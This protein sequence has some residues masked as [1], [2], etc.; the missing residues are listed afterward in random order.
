MKV[1]GLLLFSLALAAVMACFAFYVNGLLPEGT[2]LPI[3]WNAA[4]EVDGSANALTALLLPPALAAGLALLFAIVPSIEPLQE[5]LAGSAHFHRIGWI[6][7]MALMLL[8]QLVIAAPVFGL[9]IGSS[10]IVIAAGFMLM[11]M[12]NALPKTRPGFFLGIRTPWTITDTD[13]WIATHRLGGK[14]MM[15]F[16]ALIIAMAL[17]P[18]S[19]QMMPSIMVTGAIAMVGIPVIYSWWFWHGKKKQAQ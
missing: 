2:E 11:M 14:L 3:H 9:T 12:G 16:G 6:A 15:A 7:I 17:F 5:K 19:P 1:K 10:V 18:F 4:G 13:N 8:V